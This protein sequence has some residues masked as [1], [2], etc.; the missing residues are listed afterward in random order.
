MTEASTHL[1]WLRDSSV[2]VTGARISGLAVVRPLLD[3]GAL[4]T[5]TDSNRAALD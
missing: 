2:L 5:V 1:S 3:L 4:V